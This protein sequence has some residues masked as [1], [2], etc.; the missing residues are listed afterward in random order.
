MDC[1][2]VLRVRNNST[3][4]EIEEAFQK[5]AF[6]WNPDDFDEYREIALGVMEDINHARHHLLLFKKSEMANEETIL[7]KENSGCAEI[8]FSSYSGYCGTYTEPWNITGTSQDSDSHHSFKTEE[9]RGKSQAMEDKEK[10][11][12]LD[13]STIEKDFFKSASDSE[14]D[15]SFSIL[16]ETERVNLQ[17]V[18]SN[19]TEKCSQEKNIIRPDRKILSKSSSLPLIFQD[20]LPIKH[21]SNFRKAS[22]MNELKS[23]NVKSDEEAGTRHITKFVQSNPTSKCCEKNEDTLDNEKWTPSR[24]AEAVDTNQATR[25]KNAKSISSHF[26]EVYDPCQAPESEKAKSILSCSESVNDACQVTKFDKAKSISS[27]SEEIDDIRQ[28]ISKKAKSISNRF[29]EIDNTSQVSKLEKS[30]PDHFQSYTDFSRYIYESHDSAW[31]LEYK[32]EKDFGLWKK[33]NRLKLEDK[34]SSETEN[35]F[36]YV[37]DK[38][39]K[40]SADLSSAAEKNL[41]KSNRSNR[42]SNSEDRL[43]EPE[44]QTLKDA[45]RIYQDVEK[46]RMGLNLDL[47]DENK[48]NYEA[49]LK[50][51]ILENFDSKEAQVSLQDIGSTKSER[52]NKKI[53]NVVTD[54]KLLIESFFLPT[55]V[56]PKKLTES[57]SLPSL[58]QN[59]KLTAFSSLPFP[60]QPKKLTEYKSE[61][62]YEYES[63]NEHN[64][65]LTSTPLKE[66]IVQPA[67]DSKRKF[68][69]S[70]VNG[71]GEVISNGMK[72]QV[73]S[74]FQ[75]LDPLKKNALPARS[76]ATD[77]KHLVN[78]SK[79]EKNDPK[80]YKPF[81]KLSNGG[82]F[83]KHSNKKSAPASTAISDSRLE[84][85]FS[86][87]SDKKG[88]SEANTVSDSK[89]DELFK[90]SNKKGTSC[91]T[92]ISDS[93]LSE[94]IMLNSNKK[95]TANENPT[96]K[97]SQDESSKINS[98]H[99]C[100][101]R[102]SLPENNKI[103]KKVSI[104]L[105]KLPNR[106]MLKLKPGISVASENQKKLTTEKS[107]SVLEIQPQIHAGLIE[108]FNKQ[109]A[110]YKKVPSQSENRKPLYNIEYSLQIPIFPIRKIKS[111]AQFS[112]RQNSLFNTKLKKSKS[113]SNVKSVRSNNERTYSG[114]LTS[115]TLIA[116]A[117]DECEESTSEQKESS[118][119]LQTTNTG[120]EEQENKPGLPNEESKHSA[121]ANLCF[122]AV[123]SLE[124]SS[125]TTNADS[126]KTNPAAATLP[127]LF[128]E[129]LYE[130][131]KAEMLGTSREDDVISIDA[132]RTKSLQMQDGKTLKCTSLMR[133]TVITDDE[134]YS[135]FWRGKVIA[136][137]SKE[138]SPNVLNVVLIMEEL[139]LKTVYEFNDKNSETVEIYVD[140]SLRYK[141]KND[142]I[143]EIP[144][145]NEAKNFSFAP[146]IMVLMIKI[147]N[148]MFTV[149]RL[150]NSEADDIVTFIEGSLEQLSQNLN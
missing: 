43:K 100:T 69:N 30:I 46:G 107:I 104:N 19:K 148:K 82:L 27:I 144:T 125:T 139:E 6:I 112:S 63:K 110:D 1:S 93:K 90:H 118:E 11:L 86:R 134:D 53:T 64:D 71:N 38:P 102:E 142:E 10:E 34:I 68:C 117:T 115:G 76:L 2:K 54:P 105:E 78:S 131:T 15:K 14:I 122:F 126:S 116:T 59:K 140:G 132:N 149:K 50:Q 61:H 114:N 12:V 17:D 120:V 42:E 7:N 106:E 13:I 85:L 65:I 81:N 74:D 44:I 51:P 87:H 103:E 113:E 101:L 28:A 97:Q 145:P 127:N 52:N 121:C 119:K 45:R 136:S 57:S 58:L 70:I 88:T 56:Q 29:E 18:E 141:I 84:G 24:S 35:N 94:L 96:Y 146:V 130:L 91:P 62:D 109:L 147:A 92:T 150:I 79:A 133:A 36:L 39:K 73:S 47:I 108:N 124:D 89:L 138:G 60:F 49:D 111:D 26:E 23:L 8:E 129:D 21:L 48:Q 66:N 41:T 40:L 80:S 4:N 32:P 77:H 9:T 16:K 137:C 123:V 33:N 128:N 55:A 31:N 72:T 25:L 5:L 143:Y 20:A 99:F 3:V 95:D 67:F 22:S 135:E 98:G 83:L 75:A 37:V